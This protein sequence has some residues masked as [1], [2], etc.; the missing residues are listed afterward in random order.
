MMSLNSSY[1]RKG[2]E[3]TQRNSSACPDFAP[4]KEGRS[5]DDYIGLVSFAFFA[6][7]AVEKGFLG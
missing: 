2:H 4:D 7:F 1:K 6:S 3:G 5:A